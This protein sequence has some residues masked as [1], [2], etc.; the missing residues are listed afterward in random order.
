MNRLTF[1]D[2]A[3]SSSSPKPMPQFVYLAD[4]RD[5]ASMQRSGIKAEELYRRV[6]HQK[7][8]GEPMWNNLVPNMQRSQVSES[9]WTK[10]SG[11]GRIN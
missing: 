7:E 4:D 2:Q 1:L 3:S 9:V 8:Q 5:I 6:I 11:C 10:T